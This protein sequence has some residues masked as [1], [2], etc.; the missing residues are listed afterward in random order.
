MT[1]GYPQPRETQEGLLLGVVSS[2]MDMTDFG[3]GRGGLF[4]VELNGRGLFQNTSL[5]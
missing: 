2:P 4:H 5:E 1:G 3:N